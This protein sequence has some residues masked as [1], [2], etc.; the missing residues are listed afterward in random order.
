M[1]KKFPGH[2]ALRLFAQNNL[3][4]DTRE[5]I[6]KYTDED[7]EEIIRLALKDGSV[8]ILTFLRKGPEC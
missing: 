6:G 1:S 4:D 2:T 8:G 7:I 5:I 3:I